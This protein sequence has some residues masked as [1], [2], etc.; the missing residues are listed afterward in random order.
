MFLVTIVTLITFSVNTLSLDA[1]FVFNSFIKTTSH[2]HRSHIDHFFG[3]HI[4]KWWHAFLRLIQVICSSVF[5]HFIT[6]GTPAKEHSS[7]SLNTTYKEESKSR[8]H[9]PCP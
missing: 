7:L 2:M 3:N 5:H 4:F 8:K 6:L 1:I 9:Y